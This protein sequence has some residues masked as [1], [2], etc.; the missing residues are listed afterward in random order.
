MEVSMI[1]TDF[2]IPI[3]DNTDNVLDLKVLWFWLSKALEQA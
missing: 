1:S 2:A 3:N